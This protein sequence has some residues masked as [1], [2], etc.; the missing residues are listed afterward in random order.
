VDGNRVHGSPTFKMGSS[1]VFRLRECSDCEVVLW[2]KPLTP[3]GLNHSLGTLAVY[4]SALNA[5]GKFSRETQNPSKATSWGFN[6]PSGHQPNKSSVYSRLQS[7]IS[8][9]RPELRRSTTVRQ[10]IPEPWGVFQEQSV[11]GRFTRSQVSN[12]ERPGAPAG[13]SRIRRQRG[14]IRVVPTCSFSVR[15]CVPALPQ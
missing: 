2:C 4:T 14:R 3:I 7:P 5:F 9:L 1:L 11:A 10:A 8:R 12:C 6:S 15:V 13:G